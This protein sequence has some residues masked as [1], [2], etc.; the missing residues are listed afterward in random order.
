MEEGGG[1]NLLT[2]TV[3]QIRRQRSLRDGSL[4]LLLDIPL[5]MRLERLLELDLLRVTF[6]VVQLG[7]ETE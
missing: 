4:V 7:F 5:V 2:L 6:G 3:K 1:T